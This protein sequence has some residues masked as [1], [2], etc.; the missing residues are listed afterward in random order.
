MRIGD[1]DPE[2]IPLADQLAEVEREIE[3]RWRVF[4]KWV[5]AGRM[6]ENLK[7]KRI[8]TLIAV[9]DG[10]RA[11]VEDEKAKQGKLL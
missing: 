3:Q 7:N 8:A 2:K 5:A 6:S 10:L 9:R 1:H 11:R 4:P